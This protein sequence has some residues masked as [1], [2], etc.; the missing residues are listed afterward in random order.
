MQQTVLA[1]VSS[2][3]FTFFLNRDFLHALIVSCF[4]ANSWP[5]QPDS[6]ARGQAASAAIALPGSSAALRDSRL[7]SHLWTLNMSGCRLQ[8]RHGDITLQS[9]TV[10]L[11]IVHGLEK[12]HRF[13]INCLHHNCNSFASFEALINFKS[14]LYRFS[15]LT[16]MWPKSCKSMSRHTGAFVLDGSLFK[17]LSANSSAVFRKSN[18]K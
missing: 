2:R 16:K 12:S 8:S 15:I 5:S 4:P 7:L 3:R 11:G 1:N 6:L 10:H 17:A 18:I 14:V 9:R 13:A